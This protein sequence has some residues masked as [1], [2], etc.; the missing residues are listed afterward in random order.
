[1]STIFRVLPMIKALAQHCQTRRHLDNRD[2]K[3]PSNYSCCQRSPFSYSTMTFVPIVHYCDKPLRHLREC[4]SSSF[5]LV[6]DSPSNT[7]FF[8]TF[9]RLPNS[10][11]NPGPP[12]ISDNKGC[13]YKDADDQWKMGQAFIPTSHIMPTTIKYTTDCQDTLSVNKTLTWLWMCMLG[14]DVTKR[15][16][17]CWNTV[18]RFVHTL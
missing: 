15:T 14:A 8:H 17:I 2:I 18:F 3:H 4:K 5:D 16:S 9:V 6:N 11:V 1:M 13:R 12:R 7:A 10:S